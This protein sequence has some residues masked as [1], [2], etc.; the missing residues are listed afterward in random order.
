MTEK[1]ITGEDTHMM[2]S[3]PSYRTPLSVR[4]VRIAVTVFAFGSCL[5]FLLLRR[6]IGFLQSIETLIL[7]SI[8]MIVEYLFHC[9]LA[10]WLHVFIML[11]GLGPMLGHSYGLFY[12]TTWWDKLLHCSG[13]VAFAI[14]GYY[15]PLLIGENRMTP[16]MRLIFAVCFSMAI[17]VMWEFMEYGQDMLLGFDTQNDTLISTIHSYL[18]GDT[19]GRLG[20]IEGISEVAVNGLSIP[21]YIDIGLIDTMGDM[22]IETLG[23]VLCAV[24]LGIDRDRH[25]AIT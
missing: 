11:Y 9:R 16:A 20:R 21:G 19:T 23:A 13:G 22:L 1:G 6:P 8:P 24:A 14:V 18:L 2:L 7:I 5:C 4:V 12:T 17:S 15:L 25:P 3:Q 10:L